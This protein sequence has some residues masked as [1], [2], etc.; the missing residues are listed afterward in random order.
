MTDRLG[1]FA[2]PAPSARWRDQGEERPMQA[3]TNGE[4]KE[5]ADAVRQA[6]Q[7]IASP[8]AGDSV[9]MREEQLAA[10]RAWLHE[11]IAADDEAQRLERARLQ[12]ET[13]RMRTDG[14]AKC[15]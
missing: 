10:A 12:Q 6:E 3:T 15:A 2:P 13:E 1:S 7:R 14:E 4:H 8:G 9:E 11:R 5:A